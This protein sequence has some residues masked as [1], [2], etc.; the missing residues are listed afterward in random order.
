[1][2]VLDPELRAVLGG[3]GDISAPREEVAGIGIQPKHVFIVENLQTGLAFDDLAGTVVI[4]RLGYAVDVLDR[5]PWL[6]RAQ[7]IYWGDIDT[8]GFAILDRARTCLPGLKTVL[9]DESTLMCHRDLWVEEKDQHAS[10]E[11]PRLTPAEQKLYQS[12]KD[13]LHGQHVRLEQERIR[14]DMAWETIK[15]RIR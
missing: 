2:R 12:L 5:L 10:T 1:M 15:A 14:W 3:L 11:L 7:C 9:M 4:M 6:R 13:N 8:H